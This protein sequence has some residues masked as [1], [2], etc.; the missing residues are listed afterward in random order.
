LEYFPTQVIN[1]GVG[2]L[3]LRVR[4]FEFLFGYDFGVLAFSMFIPLG[5]AK[6]KMV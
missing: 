3:D 6:L 4:F 1:W 5:L 2:V